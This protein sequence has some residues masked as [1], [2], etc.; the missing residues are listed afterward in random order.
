MGEPSSENLL[1]GLDDARREEIEREA[2]RVSFMEE[3]ADYRWRV[4]KE[5]HRNDRFEPLDFTTRPFLEEIYRTATPR[6]VVLGS[7]QWGKALHK[8]TLVHSDCGWVR[9]SDLRVGDEISTPFGTTQHVTG[10]FP[11]GK[12]QLYRV[13][14]SDGRSLEACGEH[15]WEIYENDGHSTK[16]ARIVKTVDLV[17]MLEKAEA[18]EKFANGRITKT[19]YKIILPKALELPERSLPIDPY[20]LGQLIGDGEIHRRHIRYST[21][22]EELLVS[23][24]ASA[25][26]FDAEFVATEG[27]NYRLRNKKSSAWSRQQIPD[28][29]DELGILGRHSHN[30]FIPEQYINSSIAQR[31]AIIQGLMDTDGYSR[32]AISFS[33]SSHQLAL[34]VQKIVWSLGGIAT[35]RVKEN[36]FYTYKGEKRKGRISYTVAIRH[37]EP[38]KF[39]RLRRKISRTPE[40]YQFKTSIKLTIDSVVPTRID[41]AV[42]IAVSD[43]RH[44]YVAENAIV[45]HNTEYL[46]VTAAVCAAAG[47]R[48]FYVVDKHEKKVRMVSSRINPAFSTIPLYKQWIKDA[49]SKGKDAESLSIKNLGAGNINF[50][51]SNSAKDFASYACDM[52]IIDE[53]QLCDQ[54]NLLKIDNRLSG[55]EYRYKMIVGNPTNIGSAENANLDYEYKN[56]DQ[57]RWHVQCPFCKEY[58]LIDW[59]THIV[60]EER[61]KTGGIISVSPLDPEWDPK[62]ILD[63]RPICINC[64]GPM[65]RLTRDGKWVAHNPGHPDAGFQLSNIYNVNVPLKDMY[66]KYRKAIHD[67]SRMTVFVN[68]QLGL[69]WNF[70]GTN[71]TERMLQQCSTG[72][73]CDVD[74]YAFI[75]A[76][77]LEFVPMAD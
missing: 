50:I 71:I 56:T 31:W 30:K 47:L 24:N 59:W 41:E 36:T 53:H 52:A 73:L 72:D 1:A 19:K 26:E 18:S 32:K 46:I 34:D 69:P 15:L 39:F 68:D 48:V 60:K 16:R 64:R 62:G 28:V 77:N 76:S 40:N 74:P 55:S 63:L 38:E 42:C 54:N 6:T 35:I 25:S 21:A 9:I 75:H 43:P 23:A 33:T 22:D 4:A 65:N 13:K 29:L 17:G 57:R 67:P 49:K 12:V 2:R 3:I 5:F 37:P 45:T 27:Y 10:V 20:F 58:Q 66:E 44:L 7:V 61:N 70:D 11:Q 8:D 51:G 14:F